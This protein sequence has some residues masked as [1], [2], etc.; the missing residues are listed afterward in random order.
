MTIN[1]TTNF[2]TPVGFQLGIQ[3]FPNVAFYTQHCNI[4]GINLPEAVQS[5]RFSN[6]PQPGDKMSWDNFTLEF[7]IDERMDNYVAIWKWI[8][9]L[10]MAKDD[11]DFD[12]RKI[13]SPGV[14]Q[15]LGANNTAIRTLYFDD[16]M[17]IS[18]GTLQFTSTEGD[19]QYIQ[20]TVDFVY[21][22]YRIE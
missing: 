14:L 8:H 10:G 12:I 19:I 13:T 2:L 3:A 16:L 6:I 1:H 7:M 9:D 15:I 20:G 22:S 17:P 4:P 21:S 18:L 5:T 11:N